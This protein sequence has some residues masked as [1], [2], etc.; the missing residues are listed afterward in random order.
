MKGAEMS[1]VTIMKAGSAYPGDWSLK[2][3]ET[4]PNMNSMLEIQ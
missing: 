1:G 2:K 4:K 3:K